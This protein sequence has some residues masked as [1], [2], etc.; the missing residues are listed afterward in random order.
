[1]TATVWL[2]AS[3]NVYNDDLLPAEVGENVTVWAD[4]RDTTSDAELGVRVVSNPTGSTPVLIDSGGP[5]VD[6]FKTYPYE[7]DRPY[8]RH[9]DENFAPFNKTMLTHCTYAVLP[10]P[11]DGWIG[12]STIWG[13]GDGNF[14]TPQA[15]A[16]SLMAFVYSNAVNQDWGMPYGTWENS[17]AELKIDDIGPWDVL[18]HYYPTPGDRWNRQTAPRIISSCLRMTALDEETGQYVR[19][20]RMSFTGPPSIQYSVN[21]PSDGV[22]VNTAAGGLGSRTTPGGP[23]RFTVGD[24]PGAASY[25]YSALKGALIEMAIY[26]TIDETSLEKII[27]SVYIRYNLTMQPA[28]AYTLH[29]GQRPLEPFFPTNESVNPFWVIA[30]VRQDTN[31][32][33]HSSCQPQGQHAPRIRVSVNAPFGSPA[34]PL[35][36]D[37]DYVFMFSRERIPLLLQG[38]ATPPF[39]VVASRLTRI[40]ITFPN[41]THPDRELYDPATRDSD[42]F[43]LDTVIVTPEGESTASYYELLAD[44][45]GGMYAVIDVANM[46]S[47]RFG[48]RSLYG[49]KTAF[50]YVTIDSYRP[51]FLNAWTLQPYTLDAVCKTPLEGYDYRPRNS[52]YS[53]NQFVR[54]MAWKNFNFV[55]AVSYSGPS[56]YQWTPVS[57]VYSFMYQP[58]QVGGNTGKDREIA[59]VKCVPSESVYDFD[60]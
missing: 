21:T 49:D 18:S 13:V 39:T 29:D 26:D 41:V 40:R 38:W 1:M 32:L 8:L 43:G 4:G 55:T 28:R 33:I 53:N 12:M 52:D 27:T 47:I 20:V 15:M 34:P 44:D 25:A 60:V 14:D 42:L 48:R 51:D 57:T 5:R 3:R 37:G 56:V 10:V 23:L 46:T 31:G 58:Y 35:A 24:Y 11:D 50:V 54:P 45:G 36:V 17:R 9:P 6:F 16:P 22:A 59:I 30:L 7:W 2:I 19:H